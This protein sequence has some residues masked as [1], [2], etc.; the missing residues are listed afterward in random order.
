M[1]VWWENNDVTCANGDVIERR[2]GVRCAIGD[3]CEPQRGVWSG[4]GD[5]ICVR[6]RV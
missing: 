3:I 2:R 5:I 1:T 6:G 4:F